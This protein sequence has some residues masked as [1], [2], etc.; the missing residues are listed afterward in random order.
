RKPSEEDVGGPLA[1]ERLGEGDRGDEVTARRLQPEVVTDEV[2]DGGAGGAVQVGWLAESLLV[3]TAAAVVRVGEPP[4]VLRLAVARVRVV[5]EVEV[6][7]TQA[8][9]SRGDDWLSLEPSRA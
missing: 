9:S 1:G 8:A 5:A 6:D 7:D 2:A 4:R 3:P